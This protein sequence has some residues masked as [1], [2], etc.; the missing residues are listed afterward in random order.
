MQYLNRPE[1]TSPF[2]HL[3]QNPVIVSQPRP[4]TR[5]DNFVT[6]SN[7]EV[8][9]QRLERLVSTKLDQSMALN[10]HEGHTVVA[11]SSGEKESTKSIQIRSSVQQPLTTSPGKRRSFWQDHNTEICEQY[12][13]T[14]DEQTVVSKRQRPRMQLV[15]QVYKKHPVFKFLSVDQLILTITHTNGVVEYAKW[16]FFRR[17]K[18][19]SRSCRIIGLMPI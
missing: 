5:F 2:D 18:D 19:R 16:N 17:Q 12:Q 7:L 11:C 14:S 8:L 4:A 6:S 15:V 1:A 13:T 3:V 10:T 9:Q